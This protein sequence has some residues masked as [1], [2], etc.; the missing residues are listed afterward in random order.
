M[1]SPVSMDEI[2][3]FL[4]ELGRRTSNLTDITVDVDEDREEV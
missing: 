1:I 3:K 2:D 4:T